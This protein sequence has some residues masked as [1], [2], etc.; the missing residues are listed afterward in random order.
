MKLVKLIQ[1]SL[2]HELISN[3]NRETWRCQYFIFDSVSNNLF[4]NFGRFS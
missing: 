4:G 1:K 3:E 2:S